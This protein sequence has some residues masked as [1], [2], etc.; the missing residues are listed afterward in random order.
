MKQ[1]RTIGLIPFHQ[2]I[3]QL[4]I[5]KFLLLQWK[6]PSDPLFNLSLKPFN[7]PISFYKDFFLQKMK[8]KL[9]ENGHSHVT[10]PPL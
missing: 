8:R 3:I 2:S 5:Q 7:F 6:T 4:R 10:S 1:I 9:L